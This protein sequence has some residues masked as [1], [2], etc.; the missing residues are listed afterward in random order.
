M[1]KYLVSLSFLF[2]FADARAVV[3]IE[4]SGGHNIAQVCN[5]DYINFKE[6]KDTV[7]DKYRF[8]NSVVFI[9]DFVDW[10][11][12]DENVEFGTNVYL[13]IKNLSSKNNGQKLEHV[14]SA[15]VVNVHVRDTDN[16]YKVNFN[17]AGS[18]LFFNLVRETDYKKVFKD[19]RGIFLENIRANHPDDKMLS[20]MD[21]VSTMTEMNSVM[22]SA[23]HFNPIILMNPIKTLNRAVLID[24]LS[25]ANKGVGAD[26][27][28]ILS[29]KINNYGGHV[30]VANK[31]NDLFF[32]I[33]L[34]INRF[35]YSDNFNDFDGMAYGLDIRAKQYI[36]SF[37]LDGILGINRSA[38][39]ADNVY[40][41]GDITNN[42]KGMSEY[43]RLSVGYDIKHV[44]DFILSPFA[45]IMFQKSDII[46]VSDSDINLHT[47]I[48]GKYNFVMDGIKYEYA[49]SLATDEKANWNIETK[50]GFVSVV[51]NAGAYVGFSA[52]RD[53]FATNYKLSINA[54]MYF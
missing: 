22:N 45:G 2:L 24:F 42:P 43:A 53:E 7:A 20:A 12:W 38:F 28:Y 31:Y 39:N 23:Y 9:D 30:Y 29:D 18:D 48:T 50:V 3:P 17:T 4:N 40:I 32:K 54:K 35:S 1:N 33:G 44:S 49:A 51:D 19:S 37:W 21:R 15:D 8:D 5:Y 10:Q 13:N 47:G 6:V 52:F 41:N 46:G 34:N 25:E 11:N 14:S 27:D 36:K 16:M 26:I